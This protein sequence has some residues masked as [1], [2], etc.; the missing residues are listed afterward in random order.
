MVHIHG[1]CSNHSGSENQTRQKRQI[2]IIH[3]FKLNTMKTPITHTSTPLSDRKPNGHPVNIFAAI[4]QDNF[5]FNAVN[6]HLMMD[7]YED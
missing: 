1:H 5:N 2:R 6:S 3:L 7:D 4:A